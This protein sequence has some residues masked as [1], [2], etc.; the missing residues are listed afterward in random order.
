MEP[1]FTYTITDKAA[2]YEQ[3]ITDFLPYIADEHEEV[4]VLAN[5]TA[6]LRQAFGWFWIGFYLVRDGQLILGPFQGD[7]ACYRIRHARGVCGTAWAE[8]TTQVVPDVEQ[9]PGHIACSGSSRSEIVVPLISKGE[10]RAVL[11]IDS[12]ELATFDEVD[13]DYLER[14]CGEISS[15]IYMQ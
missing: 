12:E 10:V 2:R 5:T 7:V 13:R 14:L 11:D 6:A 4:S 3:F 8:A 15:R 1:V 9:F